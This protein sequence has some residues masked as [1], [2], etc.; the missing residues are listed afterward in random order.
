MTDLRPTP[1]DRAPQDPTAPLLGPGQW[2][3]EAPVFRKGEAPA[4][5]ALIMDGNGRWANQ[6]GLPRT[7]GH[8]AGEL[9]L[10][11][12]LAGAVEAWRAPKDTAPGSM[13]SWTPSPVRSTRA[14]AT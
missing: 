3:R 4:H 13:P 8:Q 1:M 6:Q 7:A 5:V 11:D 9:S 2:H 10:M 12:T 14:C